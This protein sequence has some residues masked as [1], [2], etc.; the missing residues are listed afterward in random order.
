MLK[1]DVRDCNKYLPFQPVKRDL[2]N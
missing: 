2:V 1:V